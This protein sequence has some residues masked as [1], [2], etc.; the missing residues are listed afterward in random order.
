[1]TETTPHTDE[2]DERD[3]SLDFDAFWASHGT[4]QTARI[5]GEDVELPSDVPL[6]LVLKANNTATQDESEIR[7]MVAELYGDHMLAHWTDD[8]MGIR[9]LSVLLAWTVARAQG[10]PI[11]FAQAAERVEQV[12]TSGPPA[13]NR[14]ERRKGKGKTKG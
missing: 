13:P 4:R 10:S 3:E 6:W 8:G 11:T 5:L 1:M 14:Q 12:V 7:R 2:R 9:Q